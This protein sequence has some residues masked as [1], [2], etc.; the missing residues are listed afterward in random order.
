MRG[1]ALSKWYDISYDRVAKDL[2]DGFTIIRPTGIETAVPLDCPVCSFLIRNQEDCISYRKYSCCSGCSLQWA[3]PNIK[4]W[5]LGWR[6]EEPEIRR[7]QIKKANL[8]SY[9]VNLSNS[10]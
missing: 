6:P 4:K 5:E 3:Q 7:L 8:P 1:S 2:D 10:T 9:M